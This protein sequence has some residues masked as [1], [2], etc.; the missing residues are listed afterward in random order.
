MA[1]WSLFLVMW[2][3]HLHLPSHQEIRKTQSFPKLCLM[4]MSRKYCVIPG[5][6]PNG[7]WDGV[8]VMSGIER[9]PEN[10]AYH[11]CSHSESTGTGLLEFQTQSGSLANPRGFEHTAI[12]QQLLQLHSLNY[13]FIWLELIPY[14]CISWL[15]FQVSCLAIGEREDSKNFWKVIKTNFQECVVVC[16]LSIVVFLLVPKEEPNGK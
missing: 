7:L 9:A 3:F 12:L 1:C 10:H 14:I 6:F 16:P 4:C 13:N 5:N 8:L 11:F 15:V 2:H